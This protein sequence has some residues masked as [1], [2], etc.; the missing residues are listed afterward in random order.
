MGTHLPCTDLRVSLSVL[1]EICSLGQFIKVS[2][3]E[4]ATDDNDCIL[5]VKAN[6]NT[7]KRGGANHISLLCHVFQT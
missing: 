6:N 7:N 5:L 4:N 3:L 1:I 2:D